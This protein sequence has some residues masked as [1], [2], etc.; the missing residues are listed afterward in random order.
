[1]STL[2]PSVFTLLDLA[3]EQDPNGKTAKLINMLAQTDDLTPRIPFM[4]CNDG[5]THVTTTITSLPT[6]DFRQINEAVSPSVGHSAQTRFGTGLITDYSKVD[7][8]LVA[9]SADPGGFRLNQAKKH[10]EAIRQKMLSTLFYGNA[11]TSPKSFNGLSRFYNS[12]STTTQISASNVIDAAGTQDSPS[13]LASIWYVSLGSDTVHGL[14]PKGLTA[15]LEHIDHGRQLVP[16][17]TGAAG[18]LITMLVDEWNW[19]AGLCIPDWRAAGRVANIDI[20]DRLAA[21]DAVLP[22]LV[23][24]LM[25][26]VE[27]GTG[28]PCLIMNRTVKYLF[29]TEVR[30]EVG[31]GGGLTYENIDG[32]R[33]T[34]W[35]G[36]PI[37]RCDGLLSTETAVS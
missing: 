23:R 15:G 19:T 10:I 26:S 28:S 31:A 4:E 36:V 12:L 22:N 30:R 1:M 5:S 13:D 8:K 11:G 3:K 6:V 18:S 14:F 25:A 17:A 35:E 9:M 32:G 2:A 33:V 29:E 37:L 20:S 24:R 27:P 34:V 16:G 21:S 7:A